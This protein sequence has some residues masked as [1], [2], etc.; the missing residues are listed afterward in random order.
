MKT[1]EK[2]GFTLIELLIVIAIIG[3]LAVAFLPS[4]LG[5]PAKGRDTQRLA[6]VSKIEN[7][8][9][10]EMLTG[11]SLPALSECLDP[12]GGAGL[13]KHLKDNVSDFGGVFPKDPQSDQKITAGAGA[14]NCTD[15]MLGYVDFA[16]GH[17]Y[18]AGVYAQVEEESNANIRC[19][20]IISAGP[21]LLLP[22]PVVLGADP[23]C[24]L[25]L[26]Q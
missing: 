11:Y 10:S 19:L 9:V 23:G 26:I 13:S 21:T 15:G 24:Y 17:E 5:A 6:S 3:I 8:M 12:A 7:F 25:T 20:D 4:L 2:K 1:M 18:T 16:D 14:A 22:D